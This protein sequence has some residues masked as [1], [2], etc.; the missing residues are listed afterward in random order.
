MKKKDN[1]I[2]HYKLVFHI[3]DE[4]GYSSQYMAVQL[5]FTSTLTC[6]RQS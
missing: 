1:E 3:Y 2:A 5:T 6:D 4:K